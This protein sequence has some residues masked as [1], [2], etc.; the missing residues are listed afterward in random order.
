MNN[1]R[2]YAI[3]TVTILAIILST[4]ALLLFPHAVYAAQSNPAT[5]PAC[6]S[7]HSIQDFKQKCETVVNSN[8]TNVWDSAVELHIHSNQSLTAA[9]L[10]NTWVSRIKQYIQEISRK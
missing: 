5:G 8:T 9:S 4:A 2:F 3:T 10:F 1:S 7:A 6:P